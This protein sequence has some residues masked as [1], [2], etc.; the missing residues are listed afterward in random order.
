MLFLKALRTTNAALEKAAFALAMVIVAAIVLALSLSAL[1]RLV[2][3]NGYDWFIELPPVLVCW[4]VFPLLGPLLRKGQHIQVN[5]VDSFSP[6]RHISFIKLINNFIALIASIIFLKA[7]YDATLLYYR[8]GQIFE[9][10]LEIPV[11]WMYLAFPT[12]FLILLLVSTE[13]VIEDLKK[14]IKSNKIAE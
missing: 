4:L 14:L 1:T 6:K 12:G 8:M 10:E 2:S 13:L 5:F 9:I 7:G 3:G 11:W